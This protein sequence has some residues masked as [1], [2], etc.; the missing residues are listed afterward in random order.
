MRGLLFFRVIYKGFYEREGMWSINR[1]S[2][3]V[4]AEFHT[5][6]GLSVWETTNPKDSFKLGSSRN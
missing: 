1:Q 3:F 4:F 2:L 6:R 5:E